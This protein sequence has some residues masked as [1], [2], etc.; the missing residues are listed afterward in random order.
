MAKKKMECNKCG[1]KMRIDKKG[2]TVVGG[3]ESPIVKLRCDKCDITRMELKT[4]IDAELAADS[5][6]FI[7]TAVYGDEYHP[8][9]CVL[10]EY[11]D[12]T[13]AKNLLGQIFIHLYYIISPHLIGFIKCNQWIQIKIRKILE[14]IVSRIKD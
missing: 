13:L 10:R 5:K 4:D 11:R 6:C 7:A 8:S 3:G 1:G 2:V 9:V 12:N 14:R